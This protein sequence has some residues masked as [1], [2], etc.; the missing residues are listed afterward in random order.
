MSFPT[1]EILP[2]GGGSW[3]L[4]A[5]F[6]IRTVRISRFLS[7]VLTVDDDDDAIHSE[8]DFFA[9]T[10]AGDGVSVRR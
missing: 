1:V 10:I 7:L 8:S 9:R 2:R 5:I 3:R 4:L 6:R